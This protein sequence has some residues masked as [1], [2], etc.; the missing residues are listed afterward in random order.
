MVRQC[1]GLQLRYRES[2]P[3]THTHRIQNTGGGKL[4][5]KVCGASCGSIGVE[6]FGNAADCS[7]GIENHHRQHTHTEYRIQV[8]ES[9]SIKCVEPHVDQL[10]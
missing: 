9:C 4:F 8:E 2:S 3:A 6:W 5:N 10:E 1:S 7:Y